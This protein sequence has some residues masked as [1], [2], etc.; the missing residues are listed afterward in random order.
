MRPGRWPSSVA[1]Q[2]RAAP[3]GFAGS[4]AASATAPAGA[5]YVAQSG[6]PW[7]T[8]LYA[9]AIL[10]T[11]GTTLAALPGGTLTL[12]KGQTLNMTGANGPLKVT[13]YDVGG[14]ETATRGGG[15]RRQAYLPPWRSTSLYCM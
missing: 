12:T 4:V 6:S 8:G 15:L 2:G 5:V 1:G 7:S 10:K 3:N 9:R 13:A 11:G 14:I